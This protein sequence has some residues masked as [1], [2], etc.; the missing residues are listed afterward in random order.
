MNNYY[1]TGQFAKLANV[2][3]RTIRYYDKIGLLKPSCILENGY[4]QYS[5]KDFIRLQ[6][7]ITLRNLDFSI[8]D[9]F[10][11]MSSEETLK[12]SLHLQSSL[13]QAKINNLQNLK[14]AL[15]I[16]ASSIEKNAFDW[17]NL[18]SLVQMSQDNSSIINQY[19]T[20][21]N[22]DVRIA[23]HEKYS[24]N[25]M[26]WFPWLY[27]QIDFQGVNRLLEIGCGSGELWKNNTLNLRNREF[28]LSDSS[29]GMVSEVREKYGSA[30]NCIVADC[31]KIPFKD[32]YFDCV[33]ANHVLFYLQNLHQG[34]AE[35]CRVL[36]PDGVLY[37]STYGSNHMKEITALVQAFDS[38]ITLSQT[39]LYEVFGLENGKD[40]LNPYFSSVEVSYYPD[41]LIVDDAQPLVDYIMSCHGN[42]SEIIG[43]RLIEFKEF[44]QKQLPLHITKEAG[45]FICKK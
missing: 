1:S 12:D 25:P 10:S 39:N 21:K 20:S 19:M 44:I 17:S 30:F 42:Q 7:I 24:Q 31:E 9:I 2:S 37:C 32:A 36:K 6:K 14:E 8:E 26:G 33:I 43:P 40:I 5:E 4:R 35:I 34:I 28:F 22:L 16:A 27:S 11:M 45:V 41:E 38:K 29:E 15:D 13:V 18:I 23:L 3:Q